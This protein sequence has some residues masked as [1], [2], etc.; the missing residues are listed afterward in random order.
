ME[1]QRNAYEKKLYAQIQ[2][3]S[4]DIVLLTVK[5]SMARR[6]VIDIAPPPFRDVLFAYQPEIFRPVSERP[7]ISNLPYEIIVIGRRNESEIVS[8]LPHC[9]AIKYLASDA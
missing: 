7:E 9:T 4:V 6:I 2:E 1:N 5:A 3:W 8:G